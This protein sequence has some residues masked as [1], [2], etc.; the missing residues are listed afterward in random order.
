VILAKRRRSRGHCTLALPAAGRGPRRPR[1][2]SRGARDPAALG[3]GPGS[4]GCWFG[5]SWLGPGEGLGALG[6]HGP[7]DVAARRGRPA[8]GLAGS[9]GLN[10]G[11]LLRRRVNCSPRAAPV[12]S[13]RGCT[14]GSGTWPVGRGARAAGGGAGAAAGGGPPVA[15]AGAAAAGDGRPGAA[16]GGVSAMAGGGSAAAAV[17]A[18]A[19]EASATAGDGRPGAAVGEAS[20]EPVG[21]SAAG[22]GR[23]VAAAAPG[24]DRPRAAGSCWTWRG[25]SACPYPAP[26]RCPRRTGLPPPARTLFASAG[27]AEICS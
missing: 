25:P 15:A 3:L 8:P 5:P 7:L 10:R 23:G 16:V 4:G 14:R 20:A 27:A 2:P 17:A 19:G 13:P 22:A 24:G 18:A 11:G 12:W 9:S 1:V 6:S 26:C 21:G